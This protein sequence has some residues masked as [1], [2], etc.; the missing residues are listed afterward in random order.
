MWIWSLPMES[1]IYISFVVCFHSSTNSFTD[2]NF[3]TTKYNLKSF[4]HDSIKY[5]TKFEPEEEYERI[6]TCILEAADEAIMIEL[7]LIDVVR[8]EKISPR[9]FLKE[10]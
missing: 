4:E 1:K 8:K 3:S 10:R 5:W 7:N 2:N 9:T 6:K